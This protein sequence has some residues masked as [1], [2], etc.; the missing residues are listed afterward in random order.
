MQ[1][2]Q[3]TRCIMDNVGDPTIRFDENGVC[4]YCTD[5]LKAKD[6]VYHPDEYG[7][8]YLEQT[9][10]ALK[11]RRK[12][13]QYDCMLGLSGGLDSSYAAYI[14]YTYGLRMLAV[15]IDDGLDADVT[16]KNVRN[17]CDAYGI[18]LVVERPDPMLFGDLTCA[19][20]RAGVPNI[21][22][23]QDNV[24]FAC[25]YKYAKENKIDTFIS[26]GNF[27]LESILQR[28]NTYDASDKRHILAIWQRFGRIKDH[29]KIAELPLMSV[30]EKRVFYGRLHKIQ[31]IR[32]LN[33]VEYD[34]KKAFEIL[35]DTCGFE[36]YG[37][38]HCES[39]FTKLMQRYYLPQKFNVDKRKSHYSSMIISGQMTRE[40][41]I[42]R[43]KEPLYEQSS[44]EADLDFVLSKIGMSRQEFDELMKADRHM[45]NEY[46]ISILNVCARIILKLRKK[47]LK[48]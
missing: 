38:K 32:P 2:K 15:H 47:L 7:K 1:Y 11:N 6:V 30:F 37:D 17:I 21:A 36:Y 24:L 14:G 33:Y 13:F 29:K 35:H 31:T 16:T 40:E 4:N 9:F 23:P 41:A 18:D 26:G 10:T 44:L 12:N 20:I 45:H 48:Y 46:P 34:A 42:E 43:M 3:C 39:I 28:G 22:I 19:F 25:L 27:A 8:R 5:A